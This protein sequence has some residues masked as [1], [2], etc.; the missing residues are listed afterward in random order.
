MFLSVWRGLGGCSRGGRCGIVMQVFLGLDV[1]SQMW[2]VMQV[3]FFVGSGAK[4]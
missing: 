3:F 1:V 2:S 4:C